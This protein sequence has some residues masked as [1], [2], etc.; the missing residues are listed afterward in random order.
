MD[1]YRGDDR[2]LVRIEGVDVLP[3][4]QL[5]RAATPHLLPKG[6]AH[7]R[8]P[9]PAQGCDPCPPEL[10]QEGAA[11]DRILL[12][13]LINQCQPIATAHHLSFLLTP[14]R[15]RPDAYRWR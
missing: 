9:E 13:H 6:R 4:A 11:C 3:N 14:C 12:E 1:R 2:R 15:A 8:Q 7:L 10:L 5:D